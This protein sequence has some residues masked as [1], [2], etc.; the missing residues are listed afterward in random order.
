MLRVFRAT[1]APYDE[2]ITHLGGGVSLNARVSLTGTTMMIA[3]SAVGSGMGRYIGGLAPDVAFGSDGSINPIG[4]VSWVA[5]IEQK[6]SRLAS[7]GVY[8]SGVAVDARYFLDRDGSFIGFGFPGAP[9][10]NNRR[11]QELTG[12]FSRRVVK[13]AQRGS[14]QLGVQASWMKR[15]PWSTGDGPPSADAFLFFTQLRYNLP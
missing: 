3:Q 15:E 8:Y 11:I 2:S 1:L 9:Q 7:L 6:V 13:T 4:T 10:S 12:T 14:V 5:G